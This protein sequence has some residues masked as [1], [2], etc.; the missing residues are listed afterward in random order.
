MDWMNI[1]WIF[2]ALSLIGNIFVIKKNVLGQYIW[3][4]ANLCWIAFDLYLGAY[5]QAFLFAV[6][7]GMCIW[8]ILEWSKE[9]KT[10][11]A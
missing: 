6:Y 3:A 8:G 7:F 11:P 1:S 5:S 2:V 10:H 4:A 9:S